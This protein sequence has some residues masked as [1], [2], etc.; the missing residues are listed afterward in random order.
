MF[1]RPEKMNPASRIRPV[2][3]P[4]LY[5][6]V[7]ITGY[8]K[9]IMTFEMSITDLDMNRLSAIKTE[10]IDY[11]LFTREY[12]ADRQGFK[13][14]LRKPLL[15]TIDRYSILRRQIIEWRK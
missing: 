14:S 13:A 6:N 3:T 9:V 1:F 7:N 4:L 15:F 10:S 8:A 5:R 2:R 12:P 11:Y